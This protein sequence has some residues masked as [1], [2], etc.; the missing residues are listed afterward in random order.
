MPNGAHALAILPLDPTILAKAD[1]LSEVER[2]IGDVVADAAIAVCGGISDW[3]ND[4]RLSDATRTRVG[5]LFVRLFELQETTLGELNF[6]ATAR[7][8]GKR[9]IML[10]HGATL[11]QHYGPAM[12]AERLDAVLDEIIGWPLD[13]LAKVTAC[14]RAMAH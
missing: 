1:T 8:E 5:D 6:D 11:Q 7:R 2:R 14:E 12:S 3:E 4:A 10:R 13:A 9:T